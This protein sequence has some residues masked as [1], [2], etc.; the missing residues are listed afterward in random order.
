MNAAEIEAGLLAAAKL[1]NKRLVE[2]CLAC[3]A[4]INVADASGL[5]PLHYAAMFGHHD[6]VE[7]LISKGAADEYREGRET[8]DAEGVGI[9]PAV[10]VLTS[11]LHI[12]LQRGQGGEI[13]RR[14]RVI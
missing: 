13:R 11:P 1:G 12:A 2:E 14:G 10:R 4:R 3:N 8:D 9:A 6:V 7:L 5:T